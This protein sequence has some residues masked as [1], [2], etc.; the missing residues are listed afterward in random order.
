MVGIAGHAV[1]K[2]SYEEYIDLFMHIMKNRA[3]HCGLELD[4]AYKETSCTIK[5]KKK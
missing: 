5:I 1:P 2:F 3:E 4:I